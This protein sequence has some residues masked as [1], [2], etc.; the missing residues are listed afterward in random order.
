MRVTQTCASQTCVSTP[1]RSG[2]QADLHVL[3][4]LK[5]LV[6]RVLFSSYL[7]P[8][9]WGCFGPRTAHLGCST[10]SRQTSCVWLQ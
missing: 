5:D 3:P 7:T 1:A 10:T 9:I 6:L 8:R 4:L 2:K